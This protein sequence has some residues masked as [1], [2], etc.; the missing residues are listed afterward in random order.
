VV[1]LVDHPEFDP[2]LIARHAPLVF[3][4]KG[5]LRHRA[6]RGELL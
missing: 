4:A 2:D 5:L 3:D 6:F 1:V